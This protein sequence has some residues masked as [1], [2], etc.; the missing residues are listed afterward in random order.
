MAGGALLILISFGQGA[1]S[2]CWVREKKM[3][4]QCCCCWGCLGMA[5]CWK[6]NVMVERE[7]TDGEKRWRGGGGGF[8]R[9]EKGRGGAASFEKSCF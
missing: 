1:V 8:K 5:G 7:K 6:G 4:L 2:G 3:G 9:K